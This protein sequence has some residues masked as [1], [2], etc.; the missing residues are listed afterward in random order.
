MANLIV[1]SASQYEFF[2]SNGK[3]GIDAMTLYLHLLYTARLQKTN[4]IWANN[5]YLMKGLKWGEAKVKKAKS[6]LKKNDFIEYVA[7]RKKTTK[8]TERHYIKL[9][10]IHKKS[11]ILKAVEMDCII[12]NEKTT[13]T[14]LDLLGQKSTGLKS[15]RVGSKGQMLKYNNLNALS[16][17]D[18]LYI[19]SESPRKYIAY[20]K[21]IVKKK[22]YISYPDE[23]NLFWELYPNSKIKRKLFLTGLLQ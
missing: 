23:F 13:C 12:K 16:K 11:T 5:S 3:E 19:L 8:C 4:Q 20:W 7:H 9:K 18:N 17:K 1:L 21:R 2:I 15:N 10:Y 6:F 14:K 22:G